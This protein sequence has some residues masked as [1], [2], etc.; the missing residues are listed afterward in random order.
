[1]GV[2]EKKIMEKVLEIY[3]EIKTY[4]LEL[5]INHDKQKKAWIVKLSKGK[6][7]LFTHL[8]NEDAQKCLEGER[9]VRFGSQVGVF[10]DAYCKSGQACRT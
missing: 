10:I 6:D 1:M 2:D 9:C 8:E 4:G 3:P 7:E 5:A